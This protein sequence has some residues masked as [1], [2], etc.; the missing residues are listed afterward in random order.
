MENLLDENPPPEPKVKVIAI[1]LPFDLQERFHTF[2]FLHAIR[3]LYPKADLHFITP[4]KQI[5]I[6]NLLPFQAYYHEFDEN[7]IQNIF[8]V[9]R[10]CVFAKIYKVDLFIS[11]TNGFSD[12]CLGFGLWAKQRLGFSD[13]WKTL[14]LNQK[15]PRPIGHHVSEDF[16]ELYKTHVGQALDTKIKV[17]SREL[18][19]VISDYDSAPY[20][21]I[22]LSPMRGSIIDPAWKTYMEFLE[23]QRIIFFATEDQGAVALQ[24]EN[25]M[26]SLSPRNNY[27]FFPSRDWIEIGKLLAYAKGCITY[28]GAAACL[29]TYVGTKT[30]IMYDRE[31]PKRQAPFYFMADMNIMEVQ[32]PSVGVT[33]VAQ[34]IKPRAIFDM[35]GLFKRTSEFFKI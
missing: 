25:F 16:F 4:K 30:L 14:V 10:F 6:L 20:M 32:D 28:S 27:A 35:E 1:K 15:T 18:P 23:G 22:N 24:I 33:P 21:A 12:A 3:E 7:E 17:M 11:L 34:G 5:E 13:G 9:H 26:A 8:D 2:P 29:S 31:E 19:Y